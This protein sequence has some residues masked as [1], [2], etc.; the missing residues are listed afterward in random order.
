M[1][2]PS[3]TLVVRFGGSGSGLLEFE[4]LG[5]IGHSPDRLLWT[6][7]EGIARRRGIDASVT[8][9]HGKT[10]MP[11]E[12]FTGESF[13]D[14]VRTRRIGRRHNDLIRPIKRKLS[15][16]TCTPQHQRRHFTQ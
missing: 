12:S 8:P 2:S 1:F 15:S 7:D 13:A 11:R 4:T 6:R 14:H 10:T 5:L 16:G 9:T 3:G